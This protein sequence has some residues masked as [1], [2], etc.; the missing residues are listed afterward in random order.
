MI[1]KCVNIK[2]QLDYHTIR[3]DSQEINGQNILVQF[4][5]QKEYIIFKTY[6]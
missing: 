3:T 1:L 5:P 4:N 2:H 6:R